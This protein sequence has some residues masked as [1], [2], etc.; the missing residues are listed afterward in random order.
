MARTPRRV[1]V[2][3][4]RRRS[5]HDLLQNDS[6]A[7]DVSFLSSIDGSSSH[8]Q[9]LRCSPQLITVEL[10]FTNLHVIKNALHR[11][12]SYISVTHS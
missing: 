12:I 2:N 11:H 6:E 5:E 4:V 10:I 1:D 3:E 7:V 9:Q 8:T